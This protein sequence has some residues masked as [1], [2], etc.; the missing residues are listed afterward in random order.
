VLRINGDGSLSP[1]PGGV[2]SP[3]GLLPISVAVH[4]GLVYVANAGT[5]GSNYTG[6]RLGPGGRLAPIA[7]ST[8]ARSE[9]AWPAAALRLLA[10]HKRPPGASELTDRLTLHT[11][12]FFGT[13]AAA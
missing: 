3:G 13:A 10:R 2:V 6:F 9:G 1:V 12:R 4:G 11:A 7:G 5:G 8:V